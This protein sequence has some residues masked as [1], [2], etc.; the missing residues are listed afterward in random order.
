MICEQTPITPTFNEPIRD[1]PAFFKVQ[2]TPLTKPTTST[3]N[4]SE[5][6]TP[7]PKDTP[8][9]I[10]S[11]ESKFYFPTPVPKVPKKRLKDKPLL[12]FREL[13]HKI[14]NFIDNHN[15]KFPLDSQQF[16]DL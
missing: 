10:N 3:R 16:T 14:T 2:T 8:D 6:S 7:S 4:L 1:I 9:I 11:S 13:P 12:E 15:P 5:I